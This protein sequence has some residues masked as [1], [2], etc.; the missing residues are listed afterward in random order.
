MIGGELR[1]VEKR[2]LVKRMV[3]IG[4]EEMVGGE[5]ALFGTSYCARNSYIGTEV[6]YSYT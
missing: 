3:V 2:K 1:L 5:I 4:W 6:V